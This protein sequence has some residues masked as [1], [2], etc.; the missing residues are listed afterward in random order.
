MCKRGEADLS[1][2]FWGTVSGRWASQP[3]L[4]IMN[5]R[6]EIEEISRRLNYLHTINC[7]LTTFHSIQSKSVSSGPDFR[8]YLVE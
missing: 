6:N 8:G 5:R 1:W 7:L 3:T 2:V 4:H